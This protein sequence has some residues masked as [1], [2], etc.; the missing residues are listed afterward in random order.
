M[1]T[2]NQRECLQGQSKRYGTGILKNEMENVYIN[3]N[4]LHYKRCKISKRASSI[5]PKQFEDISYGQNDEFYPNT[6][7]GSNLRKI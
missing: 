2:Q 4:T 6:Y 5:F 1:L 7:L 3:S